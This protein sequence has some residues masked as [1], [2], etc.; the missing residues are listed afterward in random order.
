VPSVEEVKLH[1]SAS[2][3]EVESAVLGIRGVVERLDEAIAR[4][5]LVTAGTGHPR[6]MEAVTRL[7]AARERLTE[8]QVLASSGIEA[9]QAYHGII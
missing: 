3:G 2:V 7:E 9:A 6:A 4:L 5:R 1:V 8:A